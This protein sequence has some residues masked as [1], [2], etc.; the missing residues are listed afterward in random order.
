MEHQ[1]G[2]IRTNWQ[3][4]RDEAQLGDT[5]RR[6]LWRRQF[7]NDLAFEGLGNRLAEVVEELPRSYS[8]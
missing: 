3:A 8:V 6:L 1:I 4:I 5:D 2:V 7:L